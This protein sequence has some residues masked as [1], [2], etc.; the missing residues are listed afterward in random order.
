MPY[1][2]GYL[3]RDQTI[4]TLGGH[5]TWIKL[6]APTAEALRQA[7]LGRKSRIPAD[8]PLVPAL[9]VDTVEIEGSSILGGTTIKLSPELNSAIGGRGSGK[10]SFLEYLAFGLGR[11]CYD[12]PRDHYS[13]TTQMHE[14]INDIRRRRVDGGRPAANGLSQC[15]VLASGR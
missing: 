7:F 12:V 6:A 10:S 13:G 14:L 3:D 11:S 4:D 15:A 1:V 8:T 2:G 5:N 9:V